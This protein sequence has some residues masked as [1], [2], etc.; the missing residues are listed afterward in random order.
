[1]SYIPSVA[2]R[3]G[4]PF[5]WD[6]HKIF[7]ILLSVFFALALGSR[8][9]C[10]AD[11]ALEWNPSPSKKVVGY[12]VHSRTDDGGYYSVEDVGNVKKHV[13]RGLSKDDRYVFFVTAYDAGG[14]ESIHSNEVSWG[15]RPAGIGSGSSCLIAA[16]AY[17]DPQAREV[18]LL[19]RFRDRFLER[20]LLGRF[21][22][23]AYEWISPPLAD[24]AR[25]NE[26][27]RITTKWGLAPVIYIL[28][29]PRRSA[30][31][32]VAFLI[33]AAVGIG[34]NRKRKRKTIT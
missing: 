10:A 2:C 6:I 31:F 8:Y 26:A 4:K 20:N 27:F 33:V 7:A 22:I 25:R 5:N 24:L 15:S 28:E 19:K 21:V 32:F 14:F 11:I 17:G 9:C 16:V 34:Y 23:Q 1:M 3:I 13:V 30:V 12:K 29:R 18:L